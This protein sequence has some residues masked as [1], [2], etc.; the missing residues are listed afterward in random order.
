MPDRPG[1]QLHALLEAAAV[2]A[3]GCYDC[4]SAAVQER[5]GFPAL[6]LSGAGVAASAAGLPDLGLL[7]FEELARTARNVVNRA[8][9][10]LIVDGDTGFGNEL[11]VVR[12]VE[13]L[14]R[15]P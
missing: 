15:R 14:G 3:P 8:S 7:S 11:S 10:P 13:E 9:V 6:F 12:T 1:D 5:A 2:V 4:L